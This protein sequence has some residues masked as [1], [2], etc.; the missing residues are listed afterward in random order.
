[1]KAP[2]PF[3]SR[4]S[5]VGELLFPPLLF[6][7]SALLALKAVLPLA[8]LAD[9]GAAE[10]Y[11]F[12]DTMYMLFLALPLLICEVGCMALSLRRF[13]LLSRLTCTLLL[14]TDCLIALSLVGQIYIFVSVCASLCAGFALGF[15]IRD[16]V[17]H[18]KTSK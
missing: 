7:L 5:R 12:W 16:I 13:H 6:I 14:L 10:V 17:R 2:R 3:L 1:M 15:L 4:L 9:D 8:F 11:A 18:L